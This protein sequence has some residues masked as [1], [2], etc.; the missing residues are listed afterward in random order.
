MLYRN[1]TKRSFFNFFKN[2]STPAS[3]MES[4]RS[5]L[6][7]STQELSDLLDD[8]Q[9]PQIVNATWYMPNEK[10][11]AFEE[12]LTCRISTNTVFFD[13]DMICDTTNPSPH[14]LP[15]LE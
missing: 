9:E 8:K 10:R 12:H 14:A 13:H 6:F 3:T 2:K 5:K 4:A 7:I 15:S 11:D 1:I